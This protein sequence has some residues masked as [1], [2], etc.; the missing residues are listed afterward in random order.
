[1]DETVPRDGADALADAGPY[2]GIL[3]Q[4][5]R[6]LAEAP[7]LAEAAPRMLEAVCL[8][9]GDRKSVV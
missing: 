6:V 9:L 1:M 2:Q 7:T 4:T 8:A 5:A 3:Y